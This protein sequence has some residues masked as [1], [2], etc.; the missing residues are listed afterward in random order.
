MVIPLFHQASNPPRDFQ[1]DVGLRITAGSRRSSLQRGAHCTWHWPEK[2]RPG[3]KNVLRWHPLVMEPSW[4]NIHVI[5]WIGKIPFPEFSEA[6]I[7]RNLHGLEKV[8]VLVLFFLVSESRGAGSTLWPQWPVSFSPNTS[9]LHISSILGCLQ[10][11]A[12]CKG[13]STGKPIYQ[14]NIG[15]SS[16]NFPQPKP[17]LGFFPNLEPNLAKPRPFTVDS[18]PKSERWKR[19]DPSPS[20]LCRL[21]RHRPLP[22]CRGPSQSFPARCCQRKAGSGELE[23]SAIRHGWALE[24]HCRMMWECVGMGVSSIAQ[25]LENGIGHAKHE[26]FTI[27]HWRW[28]LPFLPSSHGSVPRFKSQPGWERHQRLAPNV[29]GEACWSTVGQHW[30]TRYYQACEWPQL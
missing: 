3:V 26:L 4:K 25:S 17:D 20:R 11:L 21:C 18:G 8:V 19:R 23:T 16:V 13:Q 2:L 22:R 15:V 29:Q 7:I 28:T 30:S 14:P 5:S 1:R 10:S 9:Y 24:T 27:L 6:L 12:C